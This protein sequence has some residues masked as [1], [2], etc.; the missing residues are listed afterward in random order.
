MHSAAQRADYV[1]KNLHKTPKYQRRQTK[2]HTAANTTQITV[3]PV[4]LPTA[5]YITSNTLKWTHYTQ[6]RTTTKAKA[7]WQSLSPFATYTNDS[8]RDSTRWFKT[9]TRTYTNY[10]Q[11][12]SQQIWPKINAVSLI[13]HLPVTSFTN[14]LNIIKKEPVKDIRL[15][16]TAWTRAL[17]G[18]PSNI[19]ENT[20]IAGRSSSVYDQKG[21]LHFYLSPFF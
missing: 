3:K 1:T 6:T 7:Q 4:V 15:P 13:L 21:W 19:A 11:N 10:F 9:R 2:V 12:N 20:L 17:Q 18:M 8:Q 14:L 5:I 16:T